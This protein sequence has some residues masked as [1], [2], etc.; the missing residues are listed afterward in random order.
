MICAVSAGRDN[1]RNKIM[2]QIGSRR[3]P[4]C[5]MIMKSRVADCG[6]RLIAQGGESRGAADR[7]GRLIGGLRLGPG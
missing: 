6:E 7:A 4:I 5:L 2:R 1:A 3:D